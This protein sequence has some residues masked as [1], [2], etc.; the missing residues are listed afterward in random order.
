[1]KSFNFLSNL[2]EKI[3]RDEKKIFKKKEE[4]RFS[5]TVQL[6]KNS[7]CDIF[8]TLVLFQSQNFIEKK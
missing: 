7:S 2:V 5:S 4:D 3:L 8:F 1:M 6:V